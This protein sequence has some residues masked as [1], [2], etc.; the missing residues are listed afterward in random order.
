MDLELAAAEDF[1]RYHV[2]VGTVLSAELN[3]RAKKPAYHLVIDFGD[4]GTKE[5]SAQLTVRYSMAQ[6][7]GRQ[8][9]AVVNF[10]PKQI[11]GVTSEVLILGA[12]V[13]ET[14]VV[15]LSPDSPVPNGMRVG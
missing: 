12:M 13:S 3:P 14:D 15:L 6:L 2:V 9:V 1:F 10:P 5:S 4:Y 8:V 11:A 7:V